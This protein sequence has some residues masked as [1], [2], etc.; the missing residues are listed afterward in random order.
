MDWFEKRIR[1]YEQK[2]WSADADQRRRLPF[3]WGLEHVG[4]PENATAPQEW[5]RNWTPRTIAGSD[6]WFDGTRAEDYEVA[7]GKD[8]D[9]VIRYSSA[10]RSPWAKNNQVYG[11][12]FRARRGGP[13]V[14]VAPQ[15]NA[16]QGE[17]VELCRW[18]KR[19]GISALRLSL[20]YHDW[21]AAPGHPRADFLVG[22]NIGLT[23][24]A[25]RQA[26][27]DLRR[28]IR[29]LE[30]EGYSGLGL[31]GTSLG[32]ALCTTVMAHERAIRAAALLHVSTYYGDVVARGVTTQHV[33]E[34]LKGHVSRGELREYWSAVS[35]I[36]YLDRLA[37]GGQRILAV[38]AR[39][40]ETFPLDLSNE[41]VKAVRRQRVE[42]ETE[43][44]ACGHYSLGD[45]PFRELAFGR[46]LPF[47]FEHLA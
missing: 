19:F 7:K 34:S 37:G 41:F 46:L 28:A 20:P 6:E 38:I 33:W 14:V 29:W 2:R 5:L 18:L 44:L 45:T 23:L 10:V 39:F 26:V 16:K 36:P 21:R 32:S 22:P 8:G 47:L 9:W 15:W 43:E 1:R 3:D 24:Q 42:C 25:N 31:V 4:G 40:D 17:Q 27:S 13:A 11:R 12:M 30:E 35:P